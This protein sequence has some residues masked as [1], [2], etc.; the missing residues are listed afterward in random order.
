[1]AKR[2]PHLGAEIMIVWELAGVWWLRLGGDA[3]REVI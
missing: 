2:R 1:M 3:N